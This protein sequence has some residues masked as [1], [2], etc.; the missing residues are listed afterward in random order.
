M[1]V[2]AACGPCAPMPGCRGVAPR[3]QP[4]ATPLQ[5]TRACLL[6]GKV[7]LICYYPGNL[8]AAGRCVCI[9]AT[10]DALSGQVCAPALP[11]CAA[12][13]H[14]APCSHQVL[15]MTHVLAG[16]MPGPTTPARAME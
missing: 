4:H 2:Q 15:M 6:A 1:T 13:G 14:P 5:K 3:N 11:A 12:A 10:P 16:S 8:Q 7:V 9:Y